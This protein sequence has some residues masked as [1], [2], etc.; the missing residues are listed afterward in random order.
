MTSIPLNFT[1]IGPKNK[2]NWYLNEGSGFWRDKTYLVL[3]SFYIYE[4]DVFL[5]QYVV[6]EED[7]SFRVY[8]FG[9]KPIPKNR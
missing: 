1:K 8:R 5:K 7:L 2:K 6:L 4:P 9:I 3:E